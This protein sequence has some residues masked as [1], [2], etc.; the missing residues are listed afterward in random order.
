VCV[1]G[2]SGSGKSTLVNELL[3]PALTGQIAGGSGRLHGFDALHGAE[4]VDQVIMV[5][6]SPIGRSARS[7]PATYLHILGEVRELLAS[8]GEARKRG[9]SAGRFSFNVAGGRCPACQ[10]MGEVR[11]EMQ[12]MADVTVPCEEC[13][14]RRFEPSTLEVKYRG[15]NI[16]DILDL[17]VDEA[18]RFFA[19]TPALGAKLWLLQRV[20]LGY[21]KL[22]QPAGTL[23][24]GESQRLKIAR[25]LARSSKEHVLYLLDEPT[26][27][28]HPEDI[29]KLVTVLG[30]LVDAGN[31]VLVIEHNLDVIKNAD[32]VVDLGVGGGP[33]GGRIVVAGPPES[34]VENEESVTGLY[35]KQVLQQRGASR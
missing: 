31:T 1:T 32:Y 20:G 25:E 2:V 10:G 12:F 14:G 3:Y 15:K 26:C 8:T 7:N 22:G 17:T 24:G 11:V 4:N 13:R 33:E 9:W 18:I 6:Q 29:R 16:A 27:G 23:S 21:L 19:D 5:D 30:E 28:L 35:L 34:L